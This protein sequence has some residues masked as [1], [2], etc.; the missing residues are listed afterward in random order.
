MG[1]W[2]FFLGQDVETSNVYRVLV[3]KPIGKR[4]LGK[5]K[6]RLEGWGG[7]AVV[8]LVEPLRY[9]SEGR[10]FDAQWCHW[11]FSL[12]SSFRPHYGPWG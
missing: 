9:K 11:N 4:A 10:G 6:S 2:A 3:E 5:P 12:T 8:Q 1:R 7:Y